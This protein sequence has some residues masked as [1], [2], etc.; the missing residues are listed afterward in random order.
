MS[1][2][3]RPEIKGLDSC[4]HGGLVRA[5]LDRLG[6]APDEVIDFSVSANPY[7][8]PP[9]VRE[10]FDSVAI[11]RY[12]DSESTELKWAIADKHGVAV[13]NIIAGSGATEIIRLVA[14]AY[15]GQG[16]TVLC[17]KP[18]FGEY[19]VA[20]RI[21][22]AAITEQWGGEED[23]FMPDIDEMLSRIEVDSPKGVFICN[24]ANPS[25]KYLGRRQV[26]RI[27]NASPL[28]LVILD[29]SYTAFTE[30][31]WDSAELLSR[32]NVAII[33]SMTKDYALAGLRLGY[34]LADEEV[35]TNLRRVCP[36]WNVNAIAQ[37]AGIV[38]L[39]DGEY[40]RKCEKKIREAKH[41]LMEGLSRLGYTVLPSSTNF[42]LV[43][44]GDA[45]MFRLHLIEKG[46]IVRDCASFG[47]PEYVRIAALKVP[48]CQRLLDVLQ[49]S[50]NEG[51]LAPPG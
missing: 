33:R 37:R 39:E 50:I 47:L 21:S 42:F 36:P 11:D 24:P 25:G 14:L 31:S 34:A 3:P 26:E 6:L 49:K 18:T 2:E 12:P 9:G 27:L 30:G 28:S 44:F 1:I 15:F 38:A 16:D 7:S 8:C 23:C 29:E 5:E 35:I 41:L 40:L 17:P 43:R 51:V 22:G 13:E 10:I 19:E 45:G 32:G 46:I 48:Q 4:H 20:C